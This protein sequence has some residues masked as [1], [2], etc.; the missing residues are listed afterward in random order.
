MCVCLSNVTCSSAAVNN[1]NSAHED[2]P[3]YS[4]N[5]GTRG[6]VKLYACNK[7]WVQTK[8]RY[9]NT[10]FYK[11]QLR[12]FFQL[13]LKIPRIMSFMNSDKVR[14]V[15]RRVLILTTLLTHPLP[16]TITLKKQKK[17]ILIT[18]QKSYRSNSRLEMTSS[19]FSQI[20]LRV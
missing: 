13:E 11:Y 20:C 2:S 6:N 8:F 4:E 10:C 7:K 3:T 1:I 12:T 9:T 19:K 18:Q 17:V 5:Q 15:T 14:I 16:I